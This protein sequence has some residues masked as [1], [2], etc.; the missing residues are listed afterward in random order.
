MLQSVTL[1]DG[2]KVLVPGI[3]PKLSETPGSI[4]WIGPELGQHNEEIISK[5]LCKQK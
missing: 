5:I 4:E 3:V 2:E 1:P